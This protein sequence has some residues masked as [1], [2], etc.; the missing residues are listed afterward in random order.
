ME[1][2]LLFEN[3]LRYETVNPITCTNLE[4]QPEIHFSSS[5]H[6]IF[7]NSLLSI[8]HENSTKNQ[9]IVF[10]TNRFENGKRRLIGGF[11]DRFKGLASAIIWSI[12]ANRSFKLD[13]THPFPL[14]QMYDFPFQQ[15]ENKGELPKIDLIDKNRVENLPSIIEGG[16]HSFTPVGDEIIFHCNSVIM[17][18]LKLDEVREKFPEVDLEQNG[19]PGQ[20]GQNELM[21]SILSIFRIRPNEKETTFLSSFISLK[22][23]FPIAIGLQFRTGG[24]GAWR[25]PE[26]GKPEEITDLIGEIDAILPEEYDK[27]LLYLATDSKEAKENL[28]HF[29]Q[30]RFSPICSN[31]PI[32]HMDRSSGDLA[33]QGSRFA[34]I[35]N[36][37]LSHCDKIF[38]VRGGF[39]KLASSR[40]NKILT[41]IGRKKISS[42]KQPSLVVKKK[43][44]SLMQNNLMSEK[45]FS[46]EHEFLYIGVP[47]AATRSIL[48]VLRGDKFATSEFNE[49]IST[50]LEKNPSHRDFF[51]FSFVRNPWSRILSTWRNKIANPNEEAPRIIIERFQELYYNMPFEEFVNFVCDSESGNDIEGDRHWTSQH[52]FLKDHEGN[53]IPDFIGRLENL[54][55]D[56]SGVLSRLGFESIALPWLNTRRG[57]SSDSKSMNSDSKKYY[58][59]FYTP[60]LAEKISER[61]KEDISYFNYKF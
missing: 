24:G 57:W 44:I 19:Q 23:H 29:S 17:D 34:I 11:A 35:E 54:E 50:H 25:D 45:L 26:W 43:N 5:N 40:A 37:L 16:I 46:K 28:L 4:L 7:H 21:S 2:S 3:I 8:L 41:R 53:M 49:P 33:I 1:E 27:A 38:A 22:R 52:L 18:F 32:A 36:H 15:I 48:S 47:K 60:E 39:A 30:P 14:G 10:S 58:R 9:S 6:E 42:P 61:Y 13:W 56:F 55:L 59:E 31:G 12:G 51:V 20:I